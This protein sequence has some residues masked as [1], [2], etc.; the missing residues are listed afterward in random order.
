MPSRSADNGRQVTGDMA[1]IASQARTDPDPIAMLEQIGAPT[2]VVVGE[3]DVP[4][5]LTMA[6]LLA[7]R[8]TRP[9]LAA[10]DT[11]LVPPAQLRGDRV[12][13]EEGVDDVG[14][15]GVDRRPARDPGS[16]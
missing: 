14:H 9:G 7:R 8:R 12:A 15:V 3:L 13:A 1:R 2:T 10:V 5:F 11:L 6:D 16:R 4:C